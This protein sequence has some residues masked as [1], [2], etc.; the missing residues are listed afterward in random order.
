MTATAVSRLVPVGTLSRGVATRRT[1]CA[2]VVG[3]SSRG[4]HQPA[5]LQCFRSV[6]LARDS[7]HRRC[8][9]VKC[10]DAPTRSTIKMVSRTTST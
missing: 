6:G 10:V 7:A 4:A 9:Q 3:L 2:K 5:G 8:V 1:I